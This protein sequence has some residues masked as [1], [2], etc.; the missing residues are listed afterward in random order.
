MDSF[1]IDEDLIRSLL[2]E[3]HADLAELDLRHAAT[4]WSNDLWRLGDEWAVRLPRRAEA[5]SELRNE[6]LW[7]PAL[8]P[9]LPLPVSTPVRIGEPTARFPWS[10]TVMTWLP[11]GPADRTPVDRGPDAAHRLAGFLRALHQPAPPEA[12]T[13]P[14]RGVDLT[15][16]TREFDE[17]IGAVTSAELADDVRNTWLDALAAPVW[18]GPPMWLHGDLHPANVLVSEGTLSGVIDFGEICAGDPAT[19]LAAA[20]LLLPVDAVSRFFDEYANADEATIRRA[21]G[22]AVLRGISLMAIGQAWERGLPGGQST[23]GPAGRAAL[24]RVLA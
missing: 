7:L 17:H 18:T 24:E 15:A 16:V 11:G 12:P 5:A 1:E 20:W 8:A 21:R 19:D 14:S 22:W 10:W 9:R 3:Q 13:N 6:Q 4:G 23:W 2:R